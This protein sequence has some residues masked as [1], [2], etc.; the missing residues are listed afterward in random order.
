MDLALVRRVRSLW[1]LSA[2]LLAHHISR[3]LLSAIAIA[4]IIMSHPSLSTHGYSS[5]P[6][7]DASHYLFDGTATTWARAIKAYF[8]R[9]L[10][11]RAWHPQSTEEGWTF[12]WCS[13]DISLCTDQREA[14]G[15]W[16]ENWDSSVANAPTFRHGAYVVSVLYFVISSDKL[17][18]ILRLSD[19]IDQIHNCW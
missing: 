5:R 4:C 1:P 3:L 6:L 12:I 8:W 13:V 11:S 18:A 16:F 7:I 17:G 19:L 9:R 2:Q 14:A 15:W 10:C